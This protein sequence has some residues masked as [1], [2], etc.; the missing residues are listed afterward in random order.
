[1]KH[2][3]AFGLLW[4][5]FSLHGQTLAE[6]FSRASFEVLQEDILLANPWVGV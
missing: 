4:S 5:A 6:G 2:A 3:V 1:M